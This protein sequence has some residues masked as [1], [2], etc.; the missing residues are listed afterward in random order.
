MK[1]KNVIFVSL[2]PFL[3][4][5][6]CTSKRQLSFLGKDWFVSNHYAEIID[7][8]SLYC[9]TL[10]QELVDSETPLIGKTDSEYLTPT[11][12][13]YLQEVLKLSRVENGEIMLF[14]HHSC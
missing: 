2:L 10:N 9:F 6:S 4:H 3:L 1:S 13:E 14:A 12:V 8:D 7:T 11:M 5:G